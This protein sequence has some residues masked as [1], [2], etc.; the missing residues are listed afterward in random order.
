[1]RLVSSFLLAF[2]TLT[3]IPVPFPKRMPFSEKMLAGSVLFFPLV[4]LLFGFAGYGAALAGVACNAIPL[5][6]V[7]VMVLWYA[8]NKFLHFDGLCDMFDGFLANRTPTERLA[9]MKDSRV[10]SFALGGGV[11]Y[12]LAKYVLLGMTAATVS[13]AVLAIIPVFGRYGMVLLAYMGR[14]PRE[15]GTAKAFIGVIPV[16]SLVLSTAVCLAVLGGY[17]F[18]MHVPLTVALA[19]V[20][21]VA[22]AFLVRAYANARIGGVTGDVLGAMNEL[23]ELAVLLLFITAYRFGIS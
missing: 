2:S 19:M 18:L 8:L 3:A 15:K 7:L 1:M 22:A 11:L 12:L 6:P 10:G 13:W 14:Y 16:L 9:I 5:I 17:A 20:F 23:T 4:G 21:T